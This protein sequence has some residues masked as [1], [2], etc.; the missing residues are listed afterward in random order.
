MSTTAQRIAEI[1]E[2]MIDTRVKQHANP[3][4]G[5]V[6]ESMN[7]SLNRDYMDARKRELADAIDSLL[8]SAP[9]R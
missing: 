7:A 3:T 9:E 1:I 6:P 5:G 8:Q 2:E 4:S